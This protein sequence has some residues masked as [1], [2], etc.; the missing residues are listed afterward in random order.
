MQGTNGN[1]YGTTYAG[2][3][4]NAGVV[5]E[6]VLDPNQMP[7]V[8]FNGANGSGPGAG[9]ALGWDGNLYGTTAGG[10]PN[11][12][13]TFFRLTYGGVL[14]PL[15]YFT[16][17]GSDGGGPYS[18]LLRRGCDFFGTT[19]SGGPYGKGTIFRVS[20][21]TNPTPCFETLYSFKNLVDGGFPDGGL[22]ADV[23]GNLYGTTTDSGTAQG[24]LYE[25]IKLPHLGHVSLAGGILSANCRD[26]QP[27]LT[28]Q[29]QYSW[30]LA[31]G[32]WSPWGPPVI[33][34]S[35]KFVVSGSVGAAHGFVRMQ[36]QPPGLVPP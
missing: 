23:R 2:G 22:A 4:N 27:G 21:T 32:S 20:L 7:V 14:T 16:E 17:T 25:V 31:P 12:A 33:A 3:S 26:A 15:H 18:P 30:T 8:Q 5:F 29:A 10:G 34:N 6:W 24:T 9:L 36:L 13:G 11:N 1:L 19:Y 35:N 28:Y